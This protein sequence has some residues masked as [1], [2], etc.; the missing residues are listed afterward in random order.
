VKDLPY[1]DRHHA[2]SA[3]G[4]LELGEIREAIRELGMIRRSFQGHPDVLEILWRVLAHEKRWNDAVEIAGEL[5]KIAP[6]RVNGWVNQSYSLHELGRTQ[7][8]LDALKAVVARFPKDSII[9]YNLACY[10]CQLGDET[11]AQNWILMAARLRPKDEIREM[12][13][14][15]PDLK[16]LR[17][18]LKDL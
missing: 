2:T 3:E 16:P 8:A 11:A 18:F 1:P 10:A 5:V 13:L 15:D 7:E 17:D 12:G 14:E 9:P 6:D 4:W